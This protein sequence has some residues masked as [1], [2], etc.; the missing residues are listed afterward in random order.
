MQPLRQ[1]RVEEHGEHQDRDDEQCAVPRLEDVP[2]VVQNQQTLDLGA[3][4]ICGEGASGLPSEDTKPANLCNK[5]V[6]TAALLEMRN[7]R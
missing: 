6:S 3:C 2:F 7:E 5:S 1:E 4:D